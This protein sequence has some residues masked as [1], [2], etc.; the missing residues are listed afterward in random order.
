MAIS[1]RGFLKRGGM[2]AAAM[3]V[4]GFSFTGWAGAK[5]AYAAEANPMLHV[6][7]RLTWGIRPQDVLKINELGIEGYIDWQLAAEQIE[8]PLIDEFLIDE[9]VLSMEAD[10]VEAEADDDYGRVYTSALWGRLYR[11]IYSER[12]LHERMVE[13]WTDHFN[14]PIPDLLAPKIIDDRTVIRKHALGNFRDLLFSSARSVAMLYYLDQA[15]S[16]KEHPN[17]NY[18]R[19]VM[20]LH[21]LGVDSGYT[22]TD[23]V[24]LARALTGWQVNESLAGGFYFNSDAH[25][26]EAKTIL[27]RTF[28][29]GRGA[30][31]GLEVLDFLAMQPATAKHLSFKLC[32]HFV[33]DTPPQSL[34]ESAAAV[35]LSSGGEIKPVLRHIF[36]AP[37]FYAATWQKFR[38]PMEALVAMLRVMSSG[39]RLNNPDPIIWALEPMGHVPYH[40][41]PPNGYPDVAEAWMNANGLLHRW[42][43]AMLLPL[44]DDGYIDGV[45]LNLNRVVPQVATVGELVDTAT[46]LVLSANIPDADRAQLVTFMTANGNEAEPLSKSMRDVKLPSLIGLLMASPYFQWK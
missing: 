30:E 39:L 21:T 32:R 1:R 33:S 43:M 38:R 20:E 40:W 16:S 17:E 11:A 27:G 29:A 10:D 15:V 41:F 22:E 6:L 35:Y 7:N 34:V 12:Q 26:Y 5:P 14:I 2:A 45:R 31:E 44:A 24:E 37:E 28:P 3:G 46:A 9:P 19:E 25:D 23:I 18:A 36:T 8:D 13:F 4:G 42:N